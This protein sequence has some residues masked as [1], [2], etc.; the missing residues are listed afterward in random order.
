MKVLI[1][2]CHGGYGISADALSMYADKKGLKY[3][4]KNE[5]MPFLD[6]A[7]GTSLS[8]YN[9][10]RNDPTLIAVF[11]ELG[12]EDFSGISANVAIVEVPDGAEYFV[13]E[14]DGLEDVSQIWITA[15]LEELAS[16]LSQE[17]LDLI[18]AGCAVKL[19]G[20]I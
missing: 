4:V 10:E 16:G 20:S 6:L 5:Y 3:S 9:I 13:D 8:S 7:D 17:K 11:E 18:K 14:Y 12:S 1:N 2:K 19:K 15:T